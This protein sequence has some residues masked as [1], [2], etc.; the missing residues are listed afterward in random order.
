MHDVHDDTLPPSLHS[1]IAQLR[2]VPPIREEWRAQLDARLATPRARGWYVRPW[3]GIAACLLCALTGAG[4]AVAIQRSR[5]QPSLSSATALPAVRFDLVAPAAARVTIV[6]DFNGWNPEA[7]PMKRSADG[8]TWQ[9]DVHLPPGHYTYG[10][11]IDGRLVRDPL[12][13]ESGGD[14]F[15][16]PSS[17]LMVSSTGGR[18]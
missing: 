3:A 2:E 17:V 12:A 11:M 15:G 13:A 5:P 6:G 7:L 1:A 16:V 10:F 18:P 4:I 14:D 8:R 9:V